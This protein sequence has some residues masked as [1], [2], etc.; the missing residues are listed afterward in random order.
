MIFLRQAFTA[1]VLISFGTTDKK[2]SDAARKY[3]SSND[4]SQG[5]I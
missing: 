3:I 2:Y 5:A 4:I 1:P